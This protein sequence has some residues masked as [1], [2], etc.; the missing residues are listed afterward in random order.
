MKNNSEHTLR[1]PDKDKQ[2]ARDE[3][4]DPISGAPGAHP[5][6]TG[7][8]AASGGVAGA[9]VGTVGGPVGAAVG[10]VAGAVAGGLAGKGVAEGLDPT[11][12]DAYWRDEYANQIYSDKNEPYETYQAAYRTGYEGFDLYPDRTFHEAEID[13]QRDYESNRGGSSLTWD[14][15]K[16]ATRDAWNRAADAASSKDRR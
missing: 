2:V 11:A 12:E 8:G 16:P 6:G 15:A 1:V 5:L 4:R 13:L 3:N 9:A 14:R 10:L 7:I